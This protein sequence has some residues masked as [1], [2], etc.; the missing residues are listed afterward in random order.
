MD[1]NYEEEREGIS[2]NTLVDEYL[3]AVQQG[4]FQLGFGSSKAGKTDK[5]GNQVII[6]IDRSR[7]HEI[8]I[9]WCCC[10][11]AP[12]HDMQLMVAGLFPA[13]F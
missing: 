9:R 8:G 5:D 4:A 3:V 1:F 11:N 2:D 7:V 12:K 13:T 10:P 6:I